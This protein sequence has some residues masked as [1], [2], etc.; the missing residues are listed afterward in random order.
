[1][2]ST[3]H[4]SSTTTLTYYIPPKVF[5]RMKKIIDKIHEAEEKKQYFYSF[6]YFPPKNDAAVE[7]L[8][9]RVERMAELEPLFV[10]V[11][12]G[13]GGSTAALSTRI[14]EEAQ[15]RGGV[16]SMLHIT[17]AG[18]TEARAAEILDDARARGIRN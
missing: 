13:A 10:D 16:V 12:W 6:E 4:S 11:T 7:N 1:N 8:L 15:T 17:C 5:C 2:N 14:A 3:L 9:E 18:L